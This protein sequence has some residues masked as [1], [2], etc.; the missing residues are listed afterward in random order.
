MT[1]ADASMLD[2]IIMFT[3]GAGVLYQ[4]V[5]AVVEG[6]R[7]LAVKVYREIARVIAEHDITLHETYG[8]DQTSEGGYNTASA[9]ESVWGLEKPEGFSSFGL[10]DSQYAESEDAACPDPLHRAH[11]EFSDKRHGETEDA[12][13]KHNVRHA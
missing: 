1:D 10:R 6:A 7:T 5:E 3:T 4:W 11:V 9:R 13:I 8:I 2:H 12:D